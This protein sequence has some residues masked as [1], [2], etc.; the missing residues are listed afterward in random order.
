MDVLDFLPGL[1]TVTVV[2]SS[3][4]DSSTSLNKENDSVETGE[5]EQKYYIIRLAYFFIKEYLVLDRI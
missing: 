2:Y 5:M 3:D 1:V 4:S